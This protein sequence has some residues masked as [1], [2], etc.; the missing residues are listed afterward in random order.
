MQET[1]DSR[2]GTG[3]RQMF[4]QRECHVSTVHGSHS[5]VCF[6]YVSV[7]ERGGVPE[8]DVG[9]GDVVLRI[10]EFVNSESQIARVRSVTPNL[11]F[12]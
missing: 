9:G 11:Q 7:A 1:A 2:L 4:N 10:N 6:A 8:T 3:K 5:T 12:C